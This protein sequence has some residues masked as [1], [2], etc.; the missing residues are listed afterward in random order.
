MTT[1]EARESAHKPPR[2]AVLQRRLFE[3]IEEAAPQ[4]LERYTKPDG[5]LLW[6]P[7]PD[8]QSI[9]ALD[10]CYESFHNWPLFYLLGGSDRFLA[11][12]Q[13]EFEVITE[14]MSRYGSGHGYPMVVKEYQPGYGLVPPRG[15]KLSLLYAL[16]REPGPCRQP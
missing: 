9:D 5:N 13:R 6:P 15:G 7:S 10:D 2:W 4:V 16:C 12:A 3:A 11:D 1:I 8:F 14:A